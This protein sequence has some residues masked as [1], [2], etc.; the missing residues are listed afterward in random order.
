MGEM[1]TIY[2]V[3]RSFISPSSSVTHFI[4]GMILL[5]LLLLFVL[6]LVDLCLMGKMTE[7][8]F[9]VFGRVDKKRHTYQLTINSSATVFKD[10]TLI[11]DPRM[12]C[13]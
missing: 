6:N 3:S 12:K 5:L 4:Y 8:L 9:T 1:Q 7:E 11:H 10:V 13:E 2:V